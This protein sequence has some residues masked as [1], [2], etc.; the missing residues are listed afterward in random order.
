M[1]TRDD[2]SRGEQRAAGVADEMATRLGRL[3]ALTAALSQALTADQVAD[4]IFA[5]GPNLLDATGSLLVLRTESGAEYVLLRSAGHPAAVLECWQRFPASIRSPI[6]DAVREGHPVVLRNPQEWH[7]RYP[8]LSGPMGPP[9]D[10]PQVAVPLSHGRVAGGLCLSFPVGR[11]FGETDQAALKVAAELCA[12]ALER[13]RLYEVERQGRQDCERELEQWR[14]SGA[15]LRPSEAWFER[16]VETAAE[17]MWVIDA[18]SR[19][20]YVNRRMGDMLGLAARD[21]LGRYPSD[22][23][24]AE[25]LEEARSLFRLKRKGDDRPFDFRLR[26]TDG[27]AIWCRIANRPLFDD[28][29]Q[30]LGVLGLF[31]DVTDRKRLEEAIRESER[32]YRTLADAVPGIV[33]S[34]EVD[35]SCDYCNQRWYDYTGL[36]ESQTLGSGARSAIHPDDRRQVDARWAEAAR[37]GEPFVCQYRLRNAAGDYRWFLGR[38]VPLKDEC[39]RVVKWFGISTDIDDQK[40]LE[41]ALEEAH[42]QKDEFLAMLAHELRN[43]LVPLRNGVYLLREAVSH[44][45]AAQKLLGMMERQ[46][47]HLVRMVDDLLDVSRISRGQI[48]LRMGPLELAGAVAQAVET[49]RPFLE[50]RRHELTVS[51]PAEPLPLEADPTR[52]AQ[53]FGN[54]LNNSA[55]YTPDGGH[56]WITAAREG[57]EVVVRVRDNGAGLPEELLPTRIFEPLT[58]ASRTLARSEG[59]LGIGLTLVRKLVELHG[60]TVEAHSNGP[61]QG[62]EFVVRLPVAGAP[63]PVTF[64][65]GARAAGDGPTRSRRVLLV[66]DSRDVADSLALLLTVKGHEVRIASDGLAALDVARAFRPDVVLLDIGLPKLDGLEVARRL[67]QEP[68]QNVLLVTLSGYGTQDDH[69]RSREA[70]CDAHLVKPVDPEVLLGML[71][72][73]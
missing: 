1:S 39:G 67:R 59:G 47:K 66:E 33:F 32:R 20:Q 71:A 70:G 46:V 48:D 41:A 54:L 3:Q 60:G 43:P 28:G 2:L 56:V 38:S 68:G 49:C 73:R 11:T 6:V 42:R 57:S 58:Q 72:E 22:F 9:G 10:G 15:A 12:Q 24:F 69:R 5:H 21:M 4:A 55:R 17:G 62:S 45:A 29:G 65:E 25:D 64:T 34:S 50:A 16:I 14:Q 36:A 52:L 61:G 23:L 31:S 51:L 13:A 35:G 63:R 26:R 30:F 19:T 53:A 18:E 8:H 27:T 7:A 44:A 37:A 40:R